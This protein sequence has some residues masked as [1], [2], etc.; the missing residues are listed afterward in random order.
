MKWPLMHDAVTASDKLALV[1][2]ILNSDRY[3]NGVKVKEFEA[4]W[5]K[6][7]GAKHSLMVSSGSTA[8][9][10]LIAAVKEMFG[11]KNGDKVVVPACTWVTNISP[12]FQNGLQPIFCDVNLDNY[13]F[14]L[15]N[16]KYIAQQHPDVKVVF[17][18]HL[19]G[20]PA[21]TERYKEIFPNAIHL[22]DL[23]ESHGVKDSHG[24]KHGANSTG[25]TF[26]FYFAHHITTIEGGM[27]STNN[28]DLYDLMRMK[29]SHGMAREA[30]NPEMYTSRYPDIHKAFL[31]M[32]DGYNFRSTE[33]NAVLGL[34]QLKRLDNYI[35]VRNMN[36][37]LYCELI[38]AN[39]LFHKVHYYPGASNYAFPLIAQE[40]EVRDKLVK[41]LDE[42]DIEHR[43][44]IGG[45][46]LRQPFLKDYQMCTNKDLTN[47][48]IL[49]Y[50]GLYIGNS[51]FVTPTNIRVLQTVLDKL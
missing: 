29:R 37:E 45:N 14:D 24:Q 50:N 18:T 21:Y 2:F 9:T 23:C 10:L 36:L 40:K 46:L 32:T 5:S 20:F 28:D 7:L 11:L 1:N 16:L 51:P 34:E 48:D 13:S 35:K 15:D 6:W 30:V 26:S 42:H 4:E 38:N 27:I 43:P 3:T 19:M 12:V 49:H 39:P 22:D 31:F 33:L 44:V 25:S 8:N 17:T 41:L 47:A